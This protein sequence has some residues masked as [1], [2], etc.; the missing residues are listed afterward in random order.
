MSM[1]PGPV[2]DP[3]LR[4]AEKTGFAVAVSS[5]GLEYWNIGPPWCD[6]NV[7][8]LL[9]C[10]I[11]VTEAFVLNSGKSGLGQGIMGLNDSFRQHHAER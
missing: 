8:G 11:S 6:K 3:V 7:Y 2:E 5:G 1:S 4:G 9:H 10:I